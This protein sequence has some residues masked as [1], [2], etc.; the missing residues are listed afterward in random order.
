LL[1]QVF[2]GILIPFIGTVLGAGCVYFFNRNINE[3]LNKILMGFAGG[4][5]VAASVWSLIIPSMNYSE[6]MGKFAF[7]PAVV[8]LWIGALFII[9]LDRVLPCKE[10]GE[11]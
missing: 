4:V 5:M 1:F 8:G 9:L 2:A 7:V 11:K 3:K 6:S 10:I